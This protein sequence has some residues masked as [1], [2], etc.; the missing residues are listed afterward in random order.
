MIPLAACAVHL[1]CVQ[2][3]NTMPLVIEY[4]GACRAYFAVVCRAPDFNVHIFIISATLTIPISHKT[5]PEHR[6]C[7]KLGG[8][9]SMLV[10]LRT[11]TTIAG[12]HNHGDHDAQ[13]YPPIRSC[14]IGVGHLLTLLSIARL[15]ATTLRGLWLTC[16]VRIIVLSAHYPL[17]FLLNMGTA[18]PVFMAY[19]APL[20]VRLR[21]ATLPALR[22]D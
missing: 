3:V 10:P 17:F 19:R 1:T 22:P 12:E 8:C 5:A 6:R 15:A 14:T 11:V 20:P 21:R 9:R 7:E 2:L 16:S 4:I 13:P 18:L